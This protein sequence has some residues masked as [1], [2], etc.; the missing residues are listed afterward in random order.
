MASWL[1]FHGSS[2]RIV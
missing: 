2:V 1:G